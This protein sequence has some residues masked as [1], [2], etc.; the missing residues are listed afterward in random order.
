MAGVLK[1]TLIRSAIGKPEKH[2]KVLKALGLT[3]MHKTVCLADTPV[4]QGMINK[5]PHM[6]KVEEKGDEA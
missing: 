1:I 4:V 3:R 5:I 6:V 2:R